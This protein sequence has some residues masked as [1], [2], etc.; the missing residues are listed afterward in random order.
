M[1]T[2][3]R[4]PWPASPRR[5][6]GTHDCRQ[7]AGPKQF[8]EAVTLR[9]SDYVTLTQHVEASTARAGDGHRA[10]RTDQGLRPRA[11]GRRRAGHG[12]ADPALE[13]QGRRRRR[14]R[15]VRP[16]GALPGSAWRARRP[17][18]SHPLANGRARR[19]P[20]QAPGR[21]GRELR[22]TLDRPVQAAA[23]TALGATRQ[24][25]A[26]VAVQPSTGDV[27]AV[28]NRPTDAAYDR[29]IDGRYAPGST[30]RSSPPRRSCAPASRPPTPSPA[31][32]PS[33]SRQGV[34]ELRGRGGRRGAL[35]P[36]F[37]QSCNTAFVSL[38]NRLAPGALRAPRTTTASAA[39]APARCPPA[40]T[41]WRGRRR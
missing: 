15:P 37:A 19:D 24:K 17:A 3:A 7:G 10:A 18:A 41:R 14:Y 25:S 22:T 20:A 2:R 38:A 28:A 5:R 16:R 29:A 9:K 36:D 26:L 8:V 23:E 6:R 40:A 35:R 12:R 30:F 33:P 34:Q 1:S 21:K 27:L 13:G 39:R 4:P 31:R 32:R 11:P